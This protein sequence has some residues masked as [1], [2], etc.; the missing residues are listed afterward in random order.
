MYRQYTWGLNFITGHSD[1]FKPISFGQF[2]PRSY[3]TPCFNPLQKLPTFLELSAKNDYG[4]NFF[5]TRFFKN[6]RP[7]CFHIWLVWIMFEHSWTLFEQCIGQ[8]LNMVWT[9]HLDYLSLLLQ[10]QV[11]YQT[12][13]ASTKSPIFYKSIHRAQWEA[14]SKSQT[15]QI[16]D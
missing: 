5:L 8:C 14:N 1:T 4:W 15:Q 11:S 6:S 12:T 7:P 3:L 16:W 13:Q 9:R 2:Q 10:S